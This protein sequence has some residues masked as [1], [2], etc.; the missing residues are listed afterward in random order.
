MPFAMRA[1]EQPVGVVD[2]VGVGLLVGCA[3]LLAALEVFLVSLYAGSIVM[4]VSVGLAI[5]GNVA[6]P[7][8]AFGLTGSIIAAGAPFVTWLVVLFTVGLLP[9]PEG[10]II[11]PG[12]GA[13]EFVYFATLFGGIIAGAV[14]L[15]VCATPAMPKA[16]A[17]PVERADPIS[18]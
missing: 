12:A 8:L 9:R 17:P 15:V 5:V 16:V 18:R 6:L 13:P 1:P 4:P 10:D 3:A 2:W 11:V 14:M 7:R